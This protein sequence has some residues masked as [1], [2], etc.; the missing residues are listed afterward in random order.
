MSRPKK[1]KTSFVYAVGRR[2]RSV[3]RARLFKGKG[4]SLV[5]DKPL[6]DFFRGIIGTGYLKP[7]D[8]TQTT[9]KY[10]VTVRVVGGGKSGQLGAFLLALSR[11]LVKADEKFKKILR[12]N[13][14]LTRDPR[15]RER[16]KPGLASGAR[17]AKQSPK[18]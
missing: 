14:F 4:Q 6:E 7:F 9:G 8:L 10:Y 12:D 3:A 1:E 5:N 18:R 16:R 17:A 11:S 15:E 2:K 13:G